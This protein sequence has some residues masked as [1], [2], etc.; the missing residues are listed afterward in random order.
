MCEPL[1]DHRF[2]R[3]AV[4]GGWFSYTFEKPKENVKIALNLTIR[5]TD[6]DIAGADVFVNDTKVWTMDRTQQTT[7][8]MATT[9]FTQTIPI[10]E[11]LYRN[12]ESLTVKIAA[13]NHV[14]TGDVVDLRIVKEE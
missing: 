1:D 3:R 6:Q 14:M 9:F 12:A 10:P 11:E 8:A 4:N 2:W 7:K 13:K 5:V